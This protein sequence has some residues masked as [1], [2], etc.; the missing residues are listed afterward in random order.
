MAS[1]DSERPVLIGV[2]TYLE[3]ARSGVWDVPASFLPKDYLDGV[4]EAGGVAVLLPPQPVLPGVADAVVAALDGL[5]VAGGADIDPARYGQAPH[6]R[7]G[8]P[9]ADRDAWEDALLRAAIDRELPFLGICRGAQLLNVALGGSLHQ[10]LPDVVGTEAYQPAP[11]VFGS[12]TVAVEPGS[13]L[14]ALLGDEADDLA[15]HVYH[16]QS[17]DRVA[18][19]LRVTATTPD[20]VVEAVE[21]G[22]VPFGVGVQW[23]PEA[24][25]ADRRLFAGLVAAARAHRDRDRDQDDAH[26]DAHHDDDAPTN[27]RSAE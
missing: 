12:A 27:P 17:I 6:E 1:N 2:T 19:G 14:A 22:A 8:A 15:V 4:T 13:Q 16:H 24:D 11:A 3:S 9:R 26:H 23:H 21:L 7:T 10:H 25:A 20:G 5:V 18:E